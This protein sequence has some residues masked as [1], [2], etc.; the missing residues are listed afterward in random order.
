MKEKSICLCVDDFGIK[1]FCNNDADHLLASLRA[2]Y[3]I[4]FDWTGQNYCGLSIKWNYPKKYVDIS[5]PGY[6]AATLE[7]L[8]HSKPARLQFAPHRWSQ[9]AY[10]QKLQLAPIDDIPKLDI[11]GIHYLQSTVGSLLYYA[12]AVDAMMLPAINEISGRQAAPTQKTMDAC[13]MIL[14]YAATHPN[15]IVRYHASDMALHVD[16]EAAYLVLPNAG[17]RYAGHYYLSDAPP[18]VPAA[19]TD[20]QASWSNSH[21]LQNDSRCNELC[22]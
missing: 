21:G 18:A 8:Q 13:K 19:N 12:R 5:M 7:R 11:S 16:S 10:G 22:G 4:L 9:P 15:A 3:K 17:S 1:Y 2:H 20:T 6:I 14:D